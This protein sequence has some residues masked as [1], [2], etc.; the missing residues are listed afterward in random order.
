MKLNRDAF[1]TELA[2]N[3]MTL[4]DL[5]TISGINAVTLTRINKG[6]QEPQPVTVGKIAIALGCSVEQLIKSE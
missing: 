1:Y 5:S 6:I 2:R 3:C 4:K